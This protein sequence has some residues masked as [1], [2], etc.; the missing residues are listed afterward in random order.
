MG[1][2]DN[3]CDIIGVTKKKI[4]A[5][6]G[7]VNRKNKVVE[8]KI[9]NTSPDFQCVATPSF[10]GIATG[11]GNGDIRLFNG[12]GKN[13]KTLIPCF[14]DPIRSLDVTKNGDYILAT[15][16]KYIMLVNTLGDQNINGFTA[17]LKRAKKKPKT[18][19]LTPFDI[20]QYGLQNDSYTPAKFNLSKTN[21]ETHIT[22]SLGNYIIVWNFEDVKKGI[23]DSYKLTNVNEYVIK[24]I[25][26]FDKNQLLITMPNKVRLQDEKITDA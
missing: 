24:S 13:A 9:Y 19:K 4:F 11:S 14:G 17:C 6:D 1:Q 2:L 21:K 16:D 12:V 22:S 8:D 23:V 10:E 20:M 15:C 25:T 7:R 26:K 3:A 5:M 18:L